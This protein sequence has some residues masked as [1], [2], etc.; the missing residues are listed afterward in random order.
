MKEKQKTKLGSGFK[1]TSN[2]FNNFHGSNTFLKKLGL[3]L[4]E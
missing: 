2:D 3:G 1:T 4:G